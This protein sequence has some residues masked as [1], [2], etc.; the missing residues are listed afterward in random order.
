MKIILRLRIV[1]GNLMYEYFYGNF[2][3]WHIDKWKSICF[4]LPDLTDNFVTKNEAMRDM[5]KD[6]MDSTTNMESF[7]LVIEQIW[8]SDIEPPESVQAVDWSCQT[9]PDYLKFMY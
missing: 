2:I 4:C 3:K 7:R 5:W 9:R 1:A 6:V 8:F